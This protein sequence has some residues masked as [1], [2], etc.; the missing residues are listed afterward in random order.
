MKERY[1]LGNGGCGVAVCVREWYVLGMVV[2]GWRWDWIVVGVGDAGWGWG[3]ELGLELG[4]GLGVGDGDGSG[5]LGW[6]V[7][8][9]LV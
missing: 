9:W 3:W 6:G 4:M 1:L 8:G 2:A 7:L 5:D